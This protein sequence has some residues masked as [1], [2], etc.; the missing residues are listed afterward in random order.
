MIGKT[1]FSY[2]VSTCEADH[3][4]YIIQDCVYM[5]VRSDWSAE[6]QR[7]LSIWRTTRYA[8]AAMAT[9]RW[10][11]K[12]A[13][14]MQCVCVCAR[15]QPHTD[16][17]DVQKSDCDEKNCSDF[18]SQ[19]APLPWHPSC[20]RA[21]PSARSAWRLRAHCSLMQNEIIC[22]HFY[23]SNKHEQFL[24][25]LMFRVYFLSE[26]ERGGWWE[27]RVNQ[28]VDRRA[29]RVISGFHIKRTSSQHH[30]S[31]ITSSFSE[32]VQKQFFMFT[33]VTEEDAGTGG[34]PCQELQH[35][36]GWN[37]CNTKMRV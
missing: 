16:I 13:S 26:A 7:K 30:I 11:R 23:P 19:S 18:I 5:R 4:W 2:H 29:A 20:C 14:H 12:M 15:S 10:G 37:L 25:F 24:M 3:R 9:A 28:T 31:T 1:H 27:D 33:G 32:N 8:C 17:V 22:V 35:C 6:L 34:E 36:D 21:P